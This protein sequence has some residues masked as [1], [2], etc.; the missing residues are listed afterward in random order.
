MAK[1]DFDVTL[2]STESRFGM[3][4]GLKL[5]A[6]LLGTFLA[7]PAQAQEQSDAKLS[8]APGAPQVDALPGGTQPAFHQKPSAPTDWRFDFHGYFTAPLRIGLNKRDQLCERTAPGTCQA[9]P[10]QSNLVLHSPP[11]VPDDLETFTHTGVVPTPYAQLNFTY[12]NNIVTGNVFVLARTA[13]R[14]I[15]T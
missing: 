9:T 4:R 8:L 10:D 7:V 5:K 15:P 13:K 2:L 1:N 14:M 12:G 11:V 6:L 3:N